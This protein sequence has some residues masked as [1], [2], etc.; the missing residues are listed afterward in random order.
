MPKICA[1]PFWLQSHGVPGASAS[2]A[3]SSSNAEVGL[4]GE[5]QPIEPDPGHA[6][7][8]RRCAR[9]KRTCPTIRIADILERLR[10]RQPRVHCIT[11]AV[12]QNFTANM[13]LAAGAV[14]SMTIAPDE[15]GA[16]RRA[17]MRC[18]SIS[19]PSMRSGRRRRCGG[20]RSRPSW[21]MPW[22]LDPVFIDRS[23]PRAAF[24]KRSRRKKPRGDAPQP[25]RIRRAR[26]RTRPT[27]PRWRA[28]AKAARTVVALD[29]RTRSRYRRRAPR[30]D[31]Q[32]RSADGAGHRHGLRRRRR[33]S[34]RLSRGRGRRLAGDGGGC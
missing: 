8:G 22:V 31:R 32:R 27:T 13:L 9:R 34:A 19:A 18:W 30:Y 25:R 20:R 12:A 29:R 33:W 17:P 14:P 11:N 23:P 7:G 15:V 24:A 16:L 6:G 1:L 28:C 10:E 21:R 26:R 5:S 3:S 2:E 4:R